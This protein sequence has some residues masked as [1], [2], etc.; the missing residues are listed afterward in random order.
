MRGEIT[1]G[2]GKGWYTGVCWKVADNSGDQVVECDVK[3]EVAQDTLDTL[4][5]SVEDSASSTSQPMPGLLL[6]QYSRLLMSVLKVSLF[7]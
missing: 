7:D 1:L 2:Q 6:P 3:R 4:S 5:S